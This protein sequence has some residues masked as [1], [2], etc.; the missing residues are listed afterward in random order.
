MIR[1]FALL[2]GQGFS[3]DLGTFSIDGG[4]ETT[5]S[6]P[7]PLTTDL[8]SNYM[9][10]SSQVDNSDAPHQLVVTAAAAGSFYL[11]YILLQ[12]PSAFVTS[13]S[14]TTTG[15]SP[16]SSLSGTSSTVSGSVSVRP[17]DQ[18]RSGGANVGDIAGGVVGGVVALI[19]LGVV[20]VL[21]LR[22]RWKY[23]KVTPVRPSA[24]SHDRYATAALDSQR[25]DRAE[26]PR[27]EAAMREITPQAPSESGLHLILHM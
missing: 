12:S 3:G 25:Q 17:Q 26:P 5:L 13:Q 10:L 22:R 15:G 27:H 20:A 23:T 8:V 1:A 14:L 6:S 7:S 2:T 21:L 24:L 19:T 16:V 11:D 4:V 9:I 18:S